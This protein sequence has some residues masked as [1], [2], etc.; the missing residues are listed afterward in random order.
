MIV[1]K[2]KMCNGNLDMSEHKRLVKCN[3][4]DTYQSVPSVLDENKAEMVNRA[5]RY[6]QNGEFD[7]AASIYE[8]ILREDATDPEIHWSIVLCK[9]GVEY[10]EDPA[11]KR[12]IP[13]INRTQSHSI[14]QDSDYQNALAIA[15]PDAKQYYMEEAD[16]IDTIQRSIWR[17]AKDSE[18]YD[19]FISYKELG[20]DGN[21]I[22]VPH[23]E[24]AVD[25]QEIL[26]SEAYAAA[27]E[28]SAEVT[29]DI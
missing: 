17:I 12:M 18:D 20:P 21:Y 6:R 2:C 24:P 26:Y 19:V 10:V 27:S 15:E 29:A 8:Q 1:Y 14:L 7:R 4:C 23:T 13:T 5:N 3:Y 9:F 25:A 22:Y 11:T 28:V 16:K